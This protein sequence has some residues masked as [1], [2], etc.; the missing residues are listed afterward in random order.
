MFDIRIYT[1]I[2]T[3]LLGLVYSIRQQNNKNIDARKQYII[4]MCIIL[5][6]QSALRSLGVGPDTLG[7][8]IW[9]DDMIYT[10]WSSI[11][12]GFED[13]YINADNKDPGFPL[14]VK[15]FQVFS[16]DYQVFL[17]FYAIPYFVAI[18]VFLYRNTFS[19]RDAIFAFILYI[20]L[21]QII[22]LS[23]IR[24]QLTTAIALFSLE[25]IKHRDLKRFLWL[26]IP[27]SS[28]HISL[29]LVV[30]FYFLSGLKKR[31]VKYLYMIPIVLFYLIITSGRQIAAFM[32]GLTQNEYYMGYAQSSQSGGGLVYVS[33]AFLVVLFGTLNMKRIISLHDNYKIY[34]TAM[35]LMVFFAPLV[36]VDGG[37][38]RIGQ[39]FSLY[40][41]VFIPLVIN[42]LQ[43]TRESRWI[44][45]GTVIFLLIMLSLR[46][47]FDYSFFWQD[48][49][50]PLRY[51]R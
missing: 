14:I 39:Y 32:A 38:I 37:L 19:I 36:M 17:F 27:G 23:G 50:I 41:M 21:F 9:F 43:L 25:Y 31:H 47:T 2:L 24:Q 45:F 3:L 40:M 33:I 5:G 22:G 11:W 30:P 34:Y 46:N 1:F 29:L 42:H 18:G 20:A 8:K 48:S 35:A 16:K 6:L 51:Q 49:Q 7:Y 4:V 15:L 12:Y 13:T 28:I 10:S 44:V 26:I